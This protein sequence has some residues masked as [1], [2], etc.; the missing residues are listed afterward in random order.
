[1]VRR[2]TGEVAWVTGAGAGIGR[3]VALDLARRG[4]DV[5]LTARR[6]DPLEAVAREIEAIGR[7]ALVLP[8]DVAVEADLEAAVAAIVRELGRLDVAVA[9]AGYAAVGRVESTGLDVWRRQLDVN[10][11]GAVATARH[12]L[13]ELRRTRGRLVLVGSV[14]AFL[15]L[16]GQ[17]PYAASK[18][19]LAALGATLS[20]ELA[21]SGAS[22][23][24]VHPGFV[25]TDIVQVDALGRYV[26]GRT[27]RRPKLLLASPDAAARAIVTAALRREREAVFTGHGR[28]A[29]AVGRHLPGVVHRLA[30]A[31]APGQ[32]VPLRH[33]EAGAL[34]LVPAPAVEV[35]SPS[36]SWRLV[37][38][39]LWVARRRPQGILAPDTPFPA[40]ASSCRGQVVA[41]ERVRAYR[42]VCSLPGP[43]DVLPLPFPEALFLGPIAAIV[44]DA[45]FPLS[46]LGLIHVRQTLDGA[47]PLR[48]GVPLDLGA[49]VA[50]VR[51]GPRGIE[52]DLA[53]EVR[54]AAGP[55]WSALTTVLSRSPTTRG[56]GTRG[57]GEGSFTPPRASHVVAVPE[58][59]GRRYARVSDDWNPHHLWGVTARPLGYPKPIAHGMWLLARL[60][61]LLPEGTD[62]TTGRVEAAFKRP[63]PLPGELAA[64]VVPAGPSWRLDAWHPRRGEPH[65]LGTFTPR[66]AP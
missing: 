9:A 64:S 19:A 41:P 16:A 26:G 45:R 56:G 29:A 30:T 7:R 23:T 31:W 12:A 33:G 24:T 1:V 62:P 4:Y 14:A 57:T 15:P 10:L 60:L 58:D 36:A 49:R 38:R 61:G 44:T 46:P 13:P 25:A 55:A 2:A 48:A 54:D 22:C 8:G 40:L 3:A 37:T 63:V 66:P 5:A 42:E 52:V 50:E 27:D 32:A 17:A 43:D 51:R 65:V 39:A 28:I 35:G 6:R 11:L 47:R 59:T 20:V 53:L 34:P 21:G 18:A